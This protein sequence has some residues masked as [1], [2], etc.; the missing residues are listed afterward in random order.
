M[1]LG[2]SVSCKQMTESYKYLYVLVRLGRP[3]ANYSTAVAR[4]PFVHRKRNTACGG[5]LS[6]NAAPVRERKAIMMRKREKG[7]P[8]ICQGT[9][10]SSVDPAA[11]PVTV[12]SL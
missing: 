9:A 1:P 8:R 10:T 5:P 12:G 11:N 4:K 7:D 6:G 3:P 2:R